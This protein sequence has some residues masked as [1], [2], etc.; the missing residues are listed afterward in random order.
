MIQKVHLIRHGDTEG[1]KRRCYYGATDI[2]LLPEGIAQTER[3]RDEGIYPAPDT[4]EYYTTGKGRTEQTFRIIYGNRPHKVVKALRERNFG[5]FEMKNHEELMSDP[6]YR[7]WLD[8]YSA[9]NPPPGGESANEMIARIE[10]GIREVLDAQRVYL[11]AHPDAPAESVVI[12]H[13]GTI[14]LLISN[15]K[16]VADS[17]FHEWIP[18][19]A[20]GYTLVYEDGK[21]VDYLPI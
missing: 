11:A 16:G 7:D 8:H 3:Y 19:P 10:S 13:G 1:T 18:A 2:P 21:L 17:Q 5:A 6:R 20:R 4:E 14:A 15:A 9:D 12:C